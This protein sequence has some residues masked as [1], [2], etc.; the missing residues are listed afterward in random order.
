MHSI[1]TPVIHLQRRQVFSLQGRTG[2]RLDVRS[3]EV[4]ITQ[5]GDPRDLV[6][7][8]HECFTLDRTGRVLVSA[9]R[10]AS[11]AFRAEPQRAGR[12][13]RAPAKPGERPLPAGCY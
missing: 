5:D 4:W 11:F 8:P 7:G 3:G 10:D 13:T 1:S 2:Q 6:L 12:A 9:V